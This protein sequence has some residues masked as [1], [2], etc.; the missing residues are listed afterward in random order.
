MRPVDKESSRE[1]TRFYSSLI[2]GTI[3]I[4]AEIIQLIKKYVS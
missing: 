1:V 3:M 2:I 4:L